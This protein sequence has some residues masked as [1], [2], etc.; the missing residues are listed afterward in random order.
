VYISLKISAAKKMANLLVHIL[1]LLKNNG[2][3]KIAII[4]N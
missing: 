3:P 4:I 2:S 1:A